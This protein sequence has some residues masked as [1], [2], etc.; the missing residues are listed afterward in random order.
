[1]RQSDRVSE[2]VSGCLKERESLRERKRESESAGERESGR[3]RK[4]ESKREKL[5]ERDR[6]W[7]RDIFC[8]K[9]DSWVI[10]S[11]VSWLRI[12]AA[13]CILWKQ[14]SSV[15]VIHFREVWQK[16]WSLSHTH[17]Q[18]A[19]HSKSTPQ[20]IACGDQVC[21][22]QCKNKTKMSREKASESSSR[23]F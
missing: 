12:S 8:R 14:C 10:L 1:M 3:V 7:K 9:S 11:C 18:R 6:S 4:Q 19:L 17:S 20:V 15:Q 22:A 5:K 23:L 2:W 13:F 21:D 16:M